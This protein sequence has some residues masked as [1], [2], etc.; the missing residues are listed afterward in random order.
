MK[1]YTIIWKIILVVLILIIGVLIFN[2]M[3]QVDWTNITEVW[4]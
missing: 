1:D 3:Q 4:N 2:D